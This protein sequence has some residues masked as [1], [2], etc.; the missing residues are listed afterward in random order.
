M[1]LKLP[2]SIYKEYNSKVYLSLRWLLGLKLD[3][4]LSLSLHREIYTPLRLSSPLCLTQPLAA[5]LECF[6]VTSKVFRE[7][8]QPALPTFGR[9]AV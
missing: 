8:L 5:G 4:D 1:I 6:G 2:L 9:A 3:G 7:E